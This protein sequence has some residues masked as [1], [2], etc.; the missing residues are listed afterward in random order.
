MEL[1]V[2]YLERAAPDSPWPEKALAPYQRLLPG[3][4]FPLGNARIHV[5]WQ[6][7]AL[8]SYDVVVL[9]TLMSATAQRL[10]RGPLRKRRWMFWGERLGRGGRLHQVLSAP[11]NRASGIAAVGRWARRL[12]ERFPQPENF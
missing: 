3:F 7:P 10:M 12:R 8:D 9:N 4:W 6:L 1:S 11:L 5:N 2:F